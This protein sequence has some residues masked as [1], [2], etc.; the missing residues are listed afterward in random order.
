MKILKYITLSLA[1][2]LSITSCNDYLDTLPDDRAEI[3]TISQVKDLLVSAYPTVNNN[4]VNEM[5]SDNVCDYGK[6]YGSTTL[7]DQLYH[8]KDVDD[9]GNDSPFNVWSGYYESVAT[10]NHALQELKKFPVD[11]EYKA[12][13]AEAKLIR[14]YSMFQL[15]NTF[16]MSWN[17][18]KAD[19]YL[20][21]PYPYVPAK[22]IGQKY[23]RGTL[24][25]LYENINKDIEEALP[26]V[27]DNLYSV[28]KYHFNKK[29]AY[30]FAARFNLYYMNYDKCI[31]YANQV[32]GSDPTLL[33]RD[34]EQ[35]TQFGAMD[36]GKKYIQTTEKS[37]LM[38]IQSY[39]AEFYYLV[40]GIYPR[41]SHNNYIASYCTY[42]ANAPWGKGS[43]D[44]LLYYS[45]MLYGSSACVYFPKNWLNMEIT[46]KVNQTGYLHF[47]D[48]VFTGDE[49]LLCRAEAYALCK[50]HRY[51]LAINDI[52]T[53]IKTHCRET[54]GSN[55]RPVLTEESL[56][57]FFDD[58][59]YSQLVTDWNFA[60][61]TI[62]NVLH[63]QGFTVNSGTEE[64]IVNLVLHMRRLETLYQGL[65]FMD[66]K[67]Y[68]ISF[69]HPLA[70]E[71]ALIF[72]TGDLRGAVQ[73]PSDVIKAGLAANPR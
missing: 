33:M 1:L 35:Y 64:N 13:E 12:L 36:V 23:D 51:D 21:L 65:R 11:D 10:V 50:D 67:R 19:E 15:A 18:E 22:Y 42:W 16:C 56:N 69:T 30:A 66:V 53:W 63:P 47:V 14:A 26:Y 68:G 62:K 72:N 57:K 6:T 44:A 55:V 24:R 48:P 20:G 27:D 46:D 29:A 39:S 9:T 8:F 34:Y 58:M 5:M 3:N 70:R 25:A 73:L 40:A 71:E 52:N 37:N 7:K 61:V 32:L 54:S 60:D 41:F 4:T 49:T 2:G 43:T 59:D 38:L 28:P 31:E 17:P 45:N